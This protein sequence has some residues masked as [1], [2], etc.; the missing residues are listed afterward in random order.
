[1]NE[2]VDLWDEMTDD[3]PFG[4]KELEWKGWRIIIGVLYILLGVFLIIWGII[5]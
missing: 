5:E 1:M 2:E 3:I 4:M